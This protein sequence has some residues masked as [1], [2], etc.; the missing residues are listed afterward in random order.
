MQCGWGL[1][2]GSGSQGYKHARKRDSKTQTWQFRVCSL[3]TSSCSLPSSL[4]LLPPTSFTRWVLTEQTETPAKTQT[5]HTHTRKHTQTHTNTHTHTHVRAH[6]QLPHTSTHLATCWLLQTAH[7][8]E[9]SG[10]CETELCPPLRHHHHQRHFLLLHLVSVPSLG[11]AVH[12]HQVRSGT[13]AAGPPLRVLSLFPYY[14]VRSI[15]HAHPQNEKNQPANTLHN[16]PSH[17]SAQPPT[18]NNACAV[19]TFPA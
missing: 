6:T 11:A 16:S 15:S 1:G 8:R 7:T 13:F 14:H 17:P 10:M 3:A 2:L 19:L 5:R 4:H 12:A 9:Q 18:P